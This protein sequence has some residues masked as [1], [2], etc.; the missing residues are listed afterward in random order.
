VYTRTL[1]AA[2]AAAD[3][4]A[5]TKLLFFRSNAAI[6]PPNGIEICDIGPSPN[7]SF[8]LNLQKSRAVD[9]LLP[10]QNFDLP[11]YK[12]GIGWIP[13]FQHI[14]I[15]H[16]F[17]RHEAESRNRAYTQLAQNCE[18]VIVSSRAVA[19]DFAN[20]YPRYS[21]K[22]AILPF[23][24]LFAAKPD[25]PAVG[26]TLEKYRLPPKFALVPN[27]FWA[28]KNHA[29]LPP[30]LAALRNAGKSLPVVLTGAPAD[31]RDPSNT[32]VSDFLQAVA[33]QG[34]HNDIYMLGAV[35]RH[36][37]LDLLRS[38]SLIIQPSLSEGWNTT[39]EDA[40]ALGVPVACSDLQVHREQCGS[41]VFYF[42][43]KDA[44]S[45]AETLD[46]AWNASVDAQMVNAAREASS[47]HRAKLRLKEWGEG[48][49][50]AATYAHEACLRP[51]SRKT[52]V[53]NR[54]K[55]ECRKVIGK[56]KRVV[57]ALKD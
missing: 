51:R 29:I 11:P 12:A 20:L 3:R 31:Y 27:Q 48:I 49:L 19:R 54:F 17:S 7:V 26:D 47:L 8:W 33:Q 39:L 22:T 30:A 28:H 42:D 38:T 43:P 6:V 57:S 15:P 25:L 13:D 24:S 44:S 18:K 56:L 9:V 35:S 10:L 52:A 1:L 53:G 36:E 16:L 40:K 37:L 55:N 5:A 46:R 21:E 32:V 50:E 34:V 4:P 2:L 14:H 23:P 41:E 45:L